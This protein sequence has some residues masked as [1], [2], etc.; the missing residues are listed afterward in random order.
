MLTTCSVLQ[1]NW[2]ESYLWKRLFLF[3]KNM[4]SF[5]YI[6]SNEYGHP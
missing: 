5:S 6:I 4:E 3:I 2:H 1:I